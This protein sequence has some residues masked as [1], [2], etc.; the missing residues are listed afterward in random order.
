[1]V[2]TP[3][4]EVQ[5]RAL[6]EETIPSYYSSSPRAVSFVNDKYLSLAAPVIA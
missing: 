4:S 5:A 2:P 6:I 3:M 1:M